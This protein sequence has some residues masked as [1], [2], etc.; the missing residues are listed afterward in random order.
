[1]LE[2]VAKTLRRLFASEV[3]MPVWLEP[4]YTG[5]APLRWAAP[6]GAALYIAWMGLIYSNLSLNT[7]ILCNLF[8]VAGHLLGAA[9]YLPILWAWY[10]LRLNS[11][12]RKEPEYET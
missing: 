4:L 12:D 5:T 9:V 1:M 7:L 10:R 11:Y 8:A 6:F 3:P 2:V